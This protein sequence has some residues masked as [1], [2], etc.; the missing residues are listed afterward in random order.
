M[1]PLNCCVIVL[2]LAL[3]TSVRHLS[4]RAGACHTHTHEFFACAEPSE[5][6]SFFHPSRTLLL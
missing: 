4:F 2:Y 6:G 3:L 5:A 1:H